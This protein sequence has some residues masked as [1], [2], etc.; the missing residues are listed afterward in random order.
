MFAVSEAATSEMLHF[1][2]ISLGMASHALH[3]PKANHVVLDPVIWR[4]T[5]TTQS[6]PV[7]LDESS[8]LADA[9]SGVHVQ[10]Y[11]SGEVCRLVGSEVYSSSI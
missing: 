3:P 7:R 4:A 10:L 8:R 6:P 5:S 11:K 2:S 9:Y 1:N